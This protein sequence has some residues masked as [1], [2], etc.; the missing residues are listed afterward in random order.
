MIFCLASP[1]QILNAKCGKSFLFLIYA[2]IKKMNAENQKPFIGSGNASLRKR[3]HG[4][5][6]KRVKLALPIITLTNRQDGRDTRP[7][8]YYVFEPFYGSKTRRKC[9]L[10]T[11]AGSSFLRMS[12][13]NYHIKTNATN[14]L[15]N[16]GRFTSL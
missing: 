11:N 7:K 1:N 13:P 4:S 15:Q 3:L 8:L 16:K 2:S 6:L 9:T 5:W 10:L 12:P 14:T